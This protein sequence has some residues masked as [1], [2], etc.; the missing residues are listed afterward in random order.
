MDSAGLV[1]N[2]AAMMIA[3]GF[4][5]GQ[6][7][8]RKADKT[9]GQIVKIEE[10]G[11]QL[12]LE[13]ED[14]N[15]QTV[16]ASCDAFLGGQWREY[17]RGA[18]PKVLVT[19][20]IDPSHS[21]PFAVGFLRARI[22]SAMTAQWEVKGKSALTSLEMQAPKNLVALSD[23]AEKKLQLG[24]ATLRVLVED[25]STAGTNGGIQIG[26]FMKH[27]VVLAASNQFLKDSDDPSSNKGFANPCWWMKTC[28]KKE[29]SNMEWVGLNPTNDL[30]NLKKDVTLPY[31]RNFQ[32][33]T[34]GDEII[35]FQAATAKE[36]DV[37]VLQPVKRHRSS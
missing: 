29:D 23:F 9:V 34:S 36:A 17:R 13:D 27:R 5:I 12:Q 32:Y 28:E 3:N 31:L 35:V 25:P 24:C 33:I 11:V 19:K 20:T 8:I 4:Q 6:S 30:G 22:M 37:E 1:T 7:V 15:P 18:A 2:K 16:M 14:G 26:L 21:W 10:V